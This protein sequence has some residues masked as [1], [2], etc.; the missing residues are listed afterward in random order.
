MEK[1]VFLESFLAVL[2]CGAGL[3]TWGPEGP[4]RQGNNGGGERWMP[5]GE[6][7]SCLVACRE[8][9]V[10]LLVREGSSNGTAFRSQKHLKTRLTDQD[11]V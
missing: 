11:G 6:G 5:G 9:P 10:G 4:T 7:G 3:P 2:V 8:N 1:G